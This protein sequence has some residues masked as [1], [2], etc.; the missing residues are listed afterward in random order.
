VEGGIGRGLL[1]EEFRKEEDE[2]EVEFEDEG[3]IPG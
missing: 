3:F 2:F 1:L